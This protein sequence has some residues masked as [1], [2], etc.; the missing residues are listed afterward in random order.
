MYKSRR[1]LEGI[2]DVCDLFRLKL[3]IE[4]SSG[5]VRCIKQSFYKTVQ[6][7]DFMIC[8]LV[9]IDKLNYALNYRLNIFVYL[10]VIDKYMQ[11][12]D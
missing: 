8:N 1:D 6:N 5:K 12:E 4:S 3:G 10:L 2:S 9:R 7:S 11:N